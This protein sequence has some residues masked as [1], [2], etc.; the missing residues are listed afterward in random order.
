M[1]FETLRILEIM[2]SN[3]NGFGRFALGISISIHVLRGAKAVVMVELVP[4]K[5]KNS[6]AGRQLYSLLN[7][8]GL[9]FRL[10]FP[11]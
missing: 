11:L 2:M 10:Y 5:K 6:V 9:H 8:L 4:L 7:L 3:V 1:G